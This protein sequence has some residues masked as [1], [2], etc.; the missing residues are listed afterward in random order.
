MWILKIWSVPR[1]LKKA[2]ELLAM[3]EERLQRIEKVVKV[4]E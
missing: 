4:N 2:E 1:R 3:T